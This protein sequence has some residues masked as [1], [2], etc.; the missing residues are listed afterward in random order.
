MVTTNTPDPSGS[1]SAAAL[2]T[3]SG[4]PLVQTNQTIQ[5]QGQT[6]RPAFVD[7][8]NSCNIDAVTA[9]LSSNPS[10]ARRLKKCNSALD[11]LSA[12]CDLSDGGVG[13]KTIESLFRRANANNIC[14]ELDIDLFEHDQD[15]AEMT[16]LA[17]NTQ[18]GEN[19][20][21]TPSTLICFL[22]R[23]SS[24]YY[25][26]EMERQQIFSLISAY[27]AREMERAMAAKDG[28]IS[29][30]VDGKA[31]LA[32][33]ERETEHKRQLTEEQLAAVEKEK[34]DM[35]EPL[36]AMQQQI[37]AVVAK[38]AEEKADMQRKIDAVVADG[39]REWE[40]NCRLQEEIDAAMADIEREKAKAT[41]MQQKQPDAVLAEV[42]NEKADIADG[43]STGGTATGGSGG[44]GGVSAAAGG[45]T[46]APAAA[47]AASG[48]G[49]AAAA[50]LLVDAEPSFSY[51]SF[52]D[53][54]IVEGPYGSRET[55]KAAP[56]RRGS[57]GV[58]RGGDRGGKKMKAKKPKAKKS[59]A[60]DDSGGDDTGAAAA[61]AAVAS[62]TR[63]KSSSKK[64]DGRSD[65]ASGD[66]AEDSSHRPAKKHK[67][68]T[69]AGKM[70]PC[71]GDCAKKKKKKNPGIG[72]HP[73]AEG[74]GR[75]YCTT[76][77]DDGWMDGDICEE[78]L[79]NK[80]GL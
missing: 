70:K 64:R 28:A 4:P 8:N 3:R 9:L 20:L 31:R 58:G 21:M 69:K 57:T 75:A 74:C 25:R 45:G 13:A 71:F 46:S 18:M 48:G 62:R 37:D 15:L 40:K 1:S 63:K 7:Q 17:V 42:E 68:A 76:C 5:T 78:C 41:D 43:G 12:L 51:S 59:T 14:G 50:S 49:T 44:G 6:G 79:Y 77:K 80:Q 73:C 19:S 55:R 54:P 66:A 36:A 24:G 39:Q 26:D 22:S 60:T 27:C 67:S 2:V 16:I 11:I 47:T 23:L 65:K 72:E 61:A 35:E 53:L 30:L 56:G 52:I 38:A 33:R 32:V 29:D 34:A 10:F